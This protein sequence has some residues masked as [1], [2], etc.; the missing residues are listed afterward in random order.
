MNAKTLVSTILFT[1][2]VS[3]LGAC[4][5][6]GESVPETAS[7]GLPDWFTNPVYENGF[8]DTQCVASEPGIGI[9]YLRNQAVLLARAQLARQIDVRVKAMDKAYQR[10]VDTTAGTSV[11]G[12]F[13]S[14]SKQ[15]INQRLSGTQ[16]I[17]MDFITMPD[18]TQNF[19]AMVVMS[20]KATRRCS[21]I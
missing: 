21:M 8:A 17:K 11:G 20:P 13:E 18:G 6:S 9:N 15:V 16:P 3:V 10:L 7:T 5:S 4:A 12:S 2:V 19:C 14:V 1:G